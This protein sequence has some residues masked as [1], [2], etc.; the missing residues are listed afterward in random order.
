MWCIPQIDVD[1]VARMEDV[2]D[3]DP[4]KENSTNKKLA[5]SIVRDLLSS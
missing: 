3:F 5:A 4:V 2:L 1:Y